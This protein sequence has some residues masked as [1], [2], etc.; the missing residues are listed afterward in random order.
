M[1]YFDGPIGR[2]K[3]QTT[4]KNTQQYCTTK[5]YFTFHNRKKSSFDL[6]NYRSIQ[7]FH[8]KI[9]VKK[10]HKKE[11]RFD[12]QNFFLVLLQN[13]SNLSSRVQIPHHIFTRFGRYLYSTKCSW[14]VKVIVVK[15]SGAHCICC[16]LNISLV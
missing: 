12:E 4:S 5:I 13:L 16:G 1:R 15:E 8:F 9:S 10:K 7:V 2:V 6:P 3:I 11:I 14:I